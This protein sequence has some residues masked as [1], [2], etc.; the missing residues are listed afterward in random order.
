VSPRE[1]I[2]AS[3]SPRRRELLSGL[4]MRFRVVPAGIDEGALLDGGRPERL[5][6]R[7]ARAKAQAVARDHPDAAILAA[8]TLVVWRGEV[9]GKPSSADEAKRML[10]HLR[11]RWHQVVTGVA[12]L[13]PGRRRPLLAH[14]STMV[15]M[16]SYSD[17]ETEA[18]VGSGAPFDK[19]GA[20]AIQD[21][22]FGPVE[23][24]EGCYCNVV[25]LPLWTVLQ[26]LR[27]CG[28]FAAGEGMP[29]ACTACPLRPPG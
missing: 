13:P 14:V 1:L 29:A 26:M 28:I 20:Y 6:R 5:A 16:R 24:Y 23:S 25:G 8:D 4:G 12:L 18:Y 27:H 11:G 2:L 7:L 9:L 10:R 3:E 19:A 17:S 21:A 22:D 15:R